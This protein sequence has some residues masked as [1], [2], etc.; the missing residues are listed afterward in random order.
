MNLTDA[1]KL[2]VVGRG[3]EFRELRDH[4]AMKIILDILQGRAE[5]A[6]EELIEVIPEKLREKQEVVWRFRE[7]LEII[8]GFIN[9]GAHMEHQL[10]DES[11]LTE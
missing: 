7:L 10:D 4:P 5:E 9:E 3:L 6:R 2:E 8:N 11:Q 1:E